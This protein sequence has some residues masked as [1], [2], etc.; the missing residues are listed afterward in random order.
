MISHFLSSTVQGELSRQPHRQ[1]PCSTSGY[2]IQLT[3]LFDQAFLFIS[4]HPLGSIGDPEGLLDYLIG[5]GPSRSSV[6]HR[7]S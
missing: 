1:P 2:L 6:L 5:L 7:A 3:A 4:D